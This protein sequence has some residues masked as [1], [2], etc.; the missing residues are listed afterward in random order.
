MS[1]VGAEI[2]VSGTV[3]GVGY[4]YFCLKEAKKLNLVGWVKN[5]PDSSV[6][7]LVEGG[8]NSIN[9]FCEALKKGPQLALVKNVS[10][11]FLSELQHFNTF[12]IKY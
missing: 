1:Y 3:Q 11:S 2:K 5:L 4:R 6:Y 9:N 8:K 10:C 12:E 7:I